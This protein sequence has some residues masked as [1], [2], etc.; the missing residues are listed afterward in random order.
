MVERKVF[1]LGRLIPP[2]LVPCVLIVGCTI[3]TSGTPPTDADDYPHLRMG[4]PSRATEDT[5]ERNNFLMKKKFYALSWNN[6]KGTPN[7]VSWRITKEDLGNHPRSQF[8]P[9]PDLPPGFKRITP[10]DYTG[11]GFDRG[12]MC[13]HSDRAGSAEGSHATFFMTNMVPQSAENNQ[14]A[15]NE[16]ENYLRELVN[17]RHKVC[18]VVAGPAGEGGVGRN[19]PRNKTHNGRVVIPAKTWKVVLVLDHDVDSPAEITGP[20]DVRLIAVIMPNDQSVGLKWAH[21]RVPLKE[22]EELTGYTFFGRLP[23]QVIGPLK[24]MVDE[25]HIQAPPERQHHNDRE[26]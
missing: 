9:D 10:D 24:K 17:R 5:G 15:W 18:Y 13:P 4:N 8:L 26:K 21:Y 23:A 11:S 2:L 3:T 1:K 22:V 25:V 6:T 12:H 16:L 14:G 19:G 20:H 7:W